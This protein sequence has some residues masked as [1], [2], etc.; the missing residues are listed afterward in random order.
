MRGGKL[1]IRF[2]MDQITE[3]INKIESEKLPHKNC[4]VVGDNSSGKSLLLKKFI[5]QVENSDSV[6]FI[7]AVNRGFDVKKVPTTSNGIK[8]RS[9][10]LQTR[11]KD[12]F[13][14]LKDSFN[15]FG[16][17]TECVEMIYPVYEAEVQNLFFRLT[18]DQ[19][20]II[21][22]DPIGEVE[23]ENG[24]GLLS[25]GYQALIRIILELLFY[26]DTGVLKDEAWVVID[27][28][29]E[30]L[31]PKYAALIMEFLKQEFPWGKWIVTTHSCDLVAQTTNANL[32]VLD[33]GY[34]VMD[35]DDYSSVSEVQI[36]FERLFGS[37]LQEENEIENT[38]RRLLNNKINNA[39]GNK[40]DV[41]LTELQ[42][43]SL[44]ASQ[45][46]ILKQIQEW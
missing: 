39:W 17:L 23:F 13:F 19:F 16:T 22:G 1:F 31:S 20:K 46:L 5:A 45:K 44:S 21:Y 32:I 3:I 18:G 24:K 2:G 27:E 8:Y 9:S 7:D 34:E 33:N 29:D 12:D 30:F 26:Q 36:V 28:I 11:L 15:C 41:C 37:E 42:H 4:V 25:S 35:I 14:N 43:T 10:I 38:L 40:D 6:Y